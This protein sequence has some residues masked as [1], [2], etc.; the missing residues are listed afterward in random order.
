MPDER[1]ADSSH[2]MSGHDV[3]VSR[4]LPSIPYCSS[5]CIWK[6]LPLRLDSDSAAA[7]A[8][9]YMP[10]AATYFLRFVSTFMVSYPRGYERSC[11]NYF[12]YS[13]G[14]DMTSNS[15]YSY[16]YSTHKRYPLTSNLLFS[17]CRKPLRVVPD[18]NRP[19]ICAR[20]I[21]VHNLSKTPIVGLPHSPNSA[22]RRL[23][24]FQPHEH[25]ST[26]LAHR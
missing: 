13:R 15:P 9:W 5:Y 16:P 24:P 14:Y 17:V 2:A 1:L 22:I 11:R 12:S 8:C 4:S 19:R 25:T 23:D 26:R 10:L 7:E 6:D 21:R 18:S 3:G 20:Q